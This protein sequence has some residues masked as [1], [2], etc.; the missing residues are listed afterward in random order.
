MWTT[1]LEDLI[2][3][4]V[5]GD[6][7][8]V[9][10]CNN[11]FTLNRYQKDV[12]KY[13]QTLKPTQFSHLEE[14]LPRS[15]LSSDLHVREPTYK[16]QPQ[17][18]HSFQEVTKGTDITT[19]RHNS[20]RKGGS[21]TFLKS[22]WRV[23]DQRLS[24]RP[25]IQWYCSS[26]KRSRT[27]IPDTTHAQWW[28]C[29][30]KKAAMFFR[31]TPGR[32][33]WKM[34]T[35]PEFLFARSGDNVNM[36]CTASFPTTPFSVFWTLDCD[37]PTLLGDH[38]LYKGRVIFRFLSR[39]ITIENVTERDSGM[40]CCHV[41]TADGKRYP[42]NGT[43]L[44]VT[45]R[46][47]GTLGFL[48]WRLFN[49]AVQ[50]N[51][52]HTPVK[53]FIIKGI[54]DVP[55]MQVLIFLL[56]L[57]IYLITVGGNLT[58]L[59]LIFLDR[60]LHNPMYFFLGNLSVVDISCSTITLHRILLSF[61]TGDRTISVTE[62]MIQ[63]YMFGSLA[64]HELFI[65]TVM[66]YDRYVAVCNP[67]NYHMVMNRR[68]CGLLASLCWVLGFVQTLSLVGILSSYTCY[69][70]IEI[71]H[72]FCDIVPMMKMTCN[73]TSVLE[74]LFF[75]QGLFLITI[76]PFLLTFL[77]YVFI[78][79]AILKIHTGSG[80]RKAFYTCSSHMTVVVLLY[81][82]LA[83]QYLAPNSIS[84]LSSKKLFALFNT[85]VVPML[86]PLIYSL[87]NKDVKEA[88]RRKFFSAVILPAKF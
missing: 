70:S 56:V 87:K 54:S 19:I 11:V 33:I 82:T 6:H 7:D 59:L 44:E 10:L 84:S 78:I 52:S 41:E 20:Q 24:P 68:S 21:R 51:S 8:S 43:W 76:A 88:M 27:A 61:L 25:Q 12:S 5:A 18:D 42:G 40:Y 53:Y 69:T 30:W 77:P 83:S 60:H 29:C 23:A 62:C 28:R 14:E 13:L 4:S 86:N 57:V 37:D 17:D 39:R 63:T 16:T 26:A 66:S 48:N 72:F 85:A 32:E 58:I 65:L 15:L 49:S 75:F 73:D 2:L 71:D 9:Q 64:G 55:E 36:N 74:N 50:A 3:N 31:M 22:P 46:L 1:D 79:A 80:R 38:Q 45:K 35:H 81:T 34:K 67:L 47:D